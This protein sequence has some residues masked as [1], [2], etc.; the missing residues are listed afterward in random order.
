M[1]T[2]GLVSAFVMAGVAV[3]GCANTGLKTEEK[4]T[5]VEMSPMAE[6]PVDTVGTVHIWKNGD[7]ETVRV[8]VVDANSERIVSERSNGCRYSRMRKY[9]T[10]FAPTIRWENCSSSSGSRKINGRSGDQV[11][12]L[13]VGKTWSYDAQG[14]SDG[15]IWQSDRRCEVTK[16]AKIK[17]VSGTHD[18]FKVV[19]NSKWATQTWYISPKLGETVKFIRERK[20][21]SVTNIEFELLRVESPASL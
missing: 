18:T 9:Y 8:E 5:K 11:W 1:K 6:P 7:G 4:T 16:T 21:G 12:P 20:R 13:K 3:A 10:E 17:T 14:S 2:A 19:C 15:N